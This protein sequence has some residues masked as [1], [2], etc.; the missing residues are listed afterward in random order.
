MLA[1]CT[2]PHE[3]SL[4]LLARCAFPHEKSL[5]LRLNA[6]SLHPNCVP[7]AVAAEGFG[8]EAS[9]TRSGK[10][11]GRLRRSQET[12]FWRFGESRGAPR[13]SKI[14]RK[15]EKS[16]PGGVRF[17]IRFGTSVLIDFGRVFGSKMDSKMDVFLIRRRKAQLR[18]SIDFL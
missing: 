2:F 12:D 8:P 15:S 13:A 1:R 14:R 3:K 4:V 18:K 7:E 11:R 6:C 16:F 5:V 17:S 10:P 9:E